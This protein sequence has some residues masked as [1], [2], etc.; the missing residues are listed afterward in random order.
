MQYVTCGQAQMERWN[1]RFWENQQNGFKHGRKKKSVK[2]DQRCKIWIKSVPFLWLQIHMGLPV[3]KGSKHMA[4]TWYIARCTIISNIVYRPVV[5]LNFQFKER[6]IC[7]YL[8]K[9]QGC[10]YCFAFL[11]PPRNPSV[12]F[13]LIPICLYYLLPV[14]KLSVIWHDHAKLSDVVQ[15]NLKTSLSFKCVYL[16][17]SFLFDVFKNWPF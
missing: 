3:G 17:R 6:F 11:Y 10:P 12:D 13:R 15:H 14:M 2:H 5:L 7:F 8:F 16:S 4:S 1:E 9:T